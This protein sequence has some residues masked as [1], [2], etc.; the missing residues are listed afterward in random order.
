[1]ITAF[2]SLPVRDG[3]R[4]QRREQQ[5]RVQQ[6]LEH[7]LEQRPEQQRDQLERHLVAGRR[8]GDCGGARGHGHNG[9]TLRERRRLEVWG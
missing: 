3:R 2:A 5:R 9:W 4:E 1:M 6:R 7:R 8:L